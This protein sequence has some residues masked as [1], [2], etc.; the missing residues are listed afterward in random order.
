M[1]GGEQTPALQVSSLGHFLTGSGELLVVC[2]GYD[3]LCVSKKL[4]SDS[5]QNKL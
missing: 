1:S 2:T 3:Q 5:V 4:L